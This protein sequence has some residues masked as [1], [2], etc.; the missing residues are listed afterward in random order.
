MK[1]QVLV[2]KLSMVELESML[3]EKSERKIELESLLKRGDYKNLKNGEAE[4]AGVEL[5][6]DPVELHETN[7]AMRDELN[8]IEVLL[9]Q[10]E[11]RISEL[12][13]QEQMTN[14]KEMEQ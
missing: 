10:V 4:R 7:Q 2:S 11:T 13:A 8:E 12:K 5:P 6:Y 14:D 3:Q 1:N 9:P